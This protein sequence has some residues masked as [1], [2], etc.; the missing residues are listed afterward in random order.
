[1]PPL[2][3]QSHHP[4]VTDELP[5]SVGP[6]RVIVAVASR[7]EQLSPVLVRD[8]EKVRDDQTCAI[9]ARAKRML[10]MLALHEQVLAARQL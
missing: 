9:Q 7:C 2:A 4:K 10:D 3:G 5:R 8:V 1:M 6:S